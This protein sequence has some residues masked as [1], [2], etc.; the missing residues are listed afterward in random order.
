MIDQS[1]KQYQSTIFIKKIDKN[2][3]T[4]IYFLIVWN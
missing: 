2:W 1:R 3:L 4:T